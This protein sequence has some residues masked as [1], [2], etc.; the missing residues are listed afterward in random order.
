MEAARRSAGEAEASLRAQLEGGREALGG[1]YAAASLA[2]CQSVGEFDADAAVYLH[3]GRC[4]ARSLWAWR[5]TATCAIDAHA[6]SHAIGG[7]ASGRLPGPAG[8]GE[9]T[10]SWAWSLDEC[11]WC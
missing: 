6:S 4:G 8:A 11:G 1:C 9:A 3:R 10:I 5:A 7:S 2:T